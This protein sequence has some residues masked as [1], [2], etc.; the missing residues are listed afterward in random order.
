MSKNNYYLKLNFDINN[1]NYKQFN[2][3][4]DFIKNN[5]IKPH[6]ANSFYL[7]SKN[8][9]YLNDEE[10]KYEEEIKKIKRRIRRFKK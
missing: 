10:N 3:R 6:Y 8:K 7:S 1:E 2:S 5:R 9:I 4:K